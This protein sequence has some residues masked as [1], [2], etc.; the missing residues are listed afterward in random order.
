MRATHTLPSFWSTDTRNGI[1]C[2][3]SSAVS[4]LPSVSNLNSRLLL[5]L[6]SECARTATHTEPSLESMSM[7]DEHQLETSQENSSSPVAALTLFN[8][9]SAIQNAFD[10]GS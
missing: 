6:T 4:P 5:P 2:P 1:F 3:K 9:L 10:F 7:L 8:L